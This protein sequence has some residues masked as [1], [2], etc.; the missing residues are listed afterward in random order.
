MLLQLS[1]H[2]VWTGEPVLFLLFYLLDSVAEAPLFGAATA[3]VN[4]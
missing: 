4:Y 1:L 2:Y 3:L